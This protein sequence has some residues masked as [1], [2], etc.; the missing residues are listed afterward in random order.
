MREILGRRVRRALSEDAV[1]ADA[2]PD[3]IVVDGGK[4]QV[5]VV[6]AVLSDLGVHD[7][8][9]LGLAKPK[10]E[11]ARGDRAAVDKIIIPG[12][13]DPKRLRATDPALRLLQSLRDESHR[14]AVRFHRSVRRKRRLRS[15]LDDI[16]GVGPGRKAAL[17]KHLG[18]LKAVR[19][20]EEWEI[21]QVPGIGPGLAGVIRQALD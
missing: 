11:R 1:P 13:K 16:P 21:A 5:G 2:L 17:L 15:V 7:L 20:A 3:L 12:A 14:T 8:P 6:C 10:V 18:S 19:A 4:G 9:V